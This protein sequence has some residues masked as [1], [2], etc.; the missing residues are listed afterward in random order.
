[1]H[2]VIISKNYHSVSWSFYIEPEKRFGI[3]YPSEWH[4]QVQPEIKLFAAFENAPLGEYGSNFNVLCK[5]LEQP[6][7]LEEYAKM[8]M[9]EQVKR[10]PK[11]LLLTYK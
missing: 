4:I 7:V 3:N 9:N 10:A 5:D 1:M 8:Y 6:V 2:G 11:E